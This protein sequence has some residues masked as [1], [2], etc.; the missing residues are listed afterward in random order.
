MA[1]KIGSRGP[2]EAQAGNTAFAGACKP[3]LR[4]RGRDDV[5]LA[6]NGEFQVCFDAASATGLGAA[7]WSFGPFDPWSAESR[8]REAPNDT[9]A[10]TCPT[11]AGLDM[12]IGELSTTRDS[13]A[14]SEFCIKEALYG[15]QLAA[16]VHIVASM[17]I[18]EFLCDIRFHKSYVLPPNVDAGRQSP[19]RVSY[20]DYGDSNSNAV[21]LFCGALMG[22]RFCYSPLDQMAKAYNVRIIHPDRPGIGGSQPVDLE[23]RIQT[24]L[25]R[26]CALLLRVTELLPAPV[27]GKFVSVVRFVNDNVMPLAGL[28]GSFKQGIR[29]S[30]NRS[31]SLLASGSVPAPVPLTPTTLSLRTRGTSLFSHDESADLSLDDDAVVEELRSHITTFLFAECMDGIAADAQLFLRKP[32][33]ISWCSS[34]FWSDFDYAVPLFSKMIDE[35]DGVDGIGRLWAVDAFH[36]QTDALVGEKGQIW[37]DGCWMSHQLTLESFGHDDHHSNHLPFRNSY[38]YRSQIVEGTEHNYLMDPAYGASEVWLQRVRD[39]FPTPIESESDHGHQNFEEEEANGRAL[40]NASASSTRP[41]TSLRRKSIRGLVGSVR[42]KTRDTSSK[43]FRVR[44]EE[45]RSGSLEPAAKGRSRSDVLTMPRPR[46]RGFMRRL[47]SRNK[48]T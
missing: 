4:G 7:L 18:L 16:F 47:S 44:L 41:L 36:A 33:S 21:V 42:R 29:D 24:W 13:T 20:A 35:E 48:V 25:G 2:Q 10:P 9:R 30:I 43:I 17:S 19:Y 11:R 14:A 26:F 31:S 5:H 1:T 38:K 39:A 12:A 46:L 3:V 37:F 32:R 45:P 34:V 28:S 6:M 23:K 15:G 8:W 27:L 40:D 22:T